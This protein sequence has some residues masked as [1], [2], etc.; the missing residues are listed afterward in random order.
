MEKEFNNL[1]YFNPKSV[2]QHI[3]DIPIQNVAKVLEN[4]DG[5]K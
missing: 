5:S 1:L 3:P 2:M 4:Y